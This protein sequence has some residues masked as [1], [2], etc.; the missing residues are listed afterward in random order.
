MLA[1]FGARVRI[2]FRWYTGRAPLGWF[3]RPLH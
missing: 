2:P 1:I 3:T